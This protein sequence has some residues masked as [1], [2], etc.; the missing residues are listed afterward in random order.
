M[1]YKTVHARILA[2]QFKPKDVPMFADVPIKPDVLINWDV[3]DLNTVCTGKC[4]HQIYKNKIQYGFKYP[5][6]N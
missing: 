2:I 4:K 5:F 1:F 6:W 3:S